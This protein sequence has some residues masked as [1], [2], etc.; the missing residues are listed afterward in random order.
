MRLVTSKQE[1]MSSWFD[2]LTADK[3]LPDNNVATWLEQ[4]YCQ[5]SMAEAVNTVVAFAQAEK[6]KYGETHKVFIGGYSQGCIISIAT[7][8]T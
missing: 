1:E 2:Y 6:E 8:L 5:E 7:L 3:I 4:T